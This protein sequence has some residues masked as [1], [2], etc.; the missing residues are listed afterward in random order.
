MKFLQLYKT[1]VVQLI[2]NSKKNG[3][4]P[5]EDEEE[6]KGNPRQV[7]QSSQ[8]FRSCDESEELP[9]S[10]SL[11][12]R[13]QRSHSDLLVE[14]TYLTESEFVSNFHTNNDSKNSNQE[15]TL[16]FDEEEKKDAQTPP[17][18]FSA[19]VSIIMHE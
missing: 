1:C 13:N 14:G 18:V 9:D 6:T 4:P 5:Q 11:Y 2:N 7:D 3:P 19:N 17:E 15:D 16:N 10:Q 12:Q 8:V